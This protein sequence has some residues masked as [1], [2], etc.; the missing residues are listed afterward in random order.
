MCGDYCAETLVEVLNQAGAPTDSELRKAEN[1]FIPEDIREVPA[2]LPPPEQLSTVQVPHF[3]AD[4]D[5]VGAGKG[6]EV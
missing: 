5:P 3:D 4:K 6:K 1:V 2:M